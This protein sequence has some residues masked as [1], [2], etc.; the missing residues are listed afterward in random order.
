M[1]PCPPWADPRGHRAARSC[2]SYGVC[3][4]L[5][6][7]Q[8]HF[9]NMLP[10]SMKVRHFAPG[11]PRGSEVQFAGRNLERRPS[12]KKL[13]SVVVGLIAAAG[14]ANA[15][16]MPVKA[17]VM[18]PVYSWT[19]LYFGLGAGLLSSRNQATSATFQQG[20]LSFNGNPLNDSDSLN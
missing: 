13:A 19:G 2:P 10:Q 12:M 14:P 5:D 4:S 9:C 6:L 18:A 1:A 16:D 8:Y 7:S 20:A 17:P 15:A 11:C 3:R